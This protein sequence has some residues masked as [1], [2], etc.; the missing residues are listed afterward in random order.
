MIELCLARSARRASRDC[1]KGGFINKDKPETTAGIRTDSMTAINIQNKMEDLARQIRH[2]RF[3]YYVLSAPAIS[4][5][6]FDQLYRELEQL[7]KLH[8]NWSM[9]I[10][11]HRKWVAPQALSLNKCGIEFRCLAYPTQRHTRNCKNGKTGL[12]GL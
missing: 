8:P 3:L 10:A 6:E 2:H 5:S 9:P 11:L 4:D 12:I 1:F 7:E